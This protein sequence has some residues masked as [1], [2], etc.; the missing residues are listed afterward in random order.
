MYHKRRLVFPTII[1]SM[2]TLAI[3]STLYAHPC[4]DHE[5]PPVDGD[6]DLVFMDTFSGGDINDRY[7]KQG[8]CFPYSVNQDNGIL[9]IT[10]RYWDDNRDCPDWTSRRRSNGNYSRR[11]ELKP[12]ASST[13]PR[14]GQEFEWEFDLKL[15]KAS[16]QEDFVAWQVISAPWDGWDMSLRYQRG[17]WV[18]Y[19][20]K[21]GSESRTYENKTICKAQ[22]GKW[23]TFTIRFKRSINDDGYF[24]VLVDQDLKMDYKGP[25]SLSKE[26]QTMAKFGIYRG[27]PKVTDVEYITEID[28]LMITRY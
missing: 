25:T 7:R 18:A 8:G 5:D 23:V 14:H 10:N 21:G 27:N 12:K 15:V 11:T 4:P 22:I 2:I 3:S 20:R 26:D 13:Q 1:A 28:N 9:R 17:A 6:G 24:Q 19:A 16:T